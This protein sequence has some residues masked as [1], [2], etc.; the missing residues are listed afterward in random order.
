[1][2]AYSF[3]YSSF[4]SGEIAPELHGRTD[5]APSRS[6]WGKGC[7]VM[8][9]VQGPVVKRGGTRFIGE[10]KV[11]DSAVRLIDFEY[12]TEQTYILEFGDKYI[13]FYKEGGLLMVEEMVFDG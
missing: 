6:G 9:L 1:M 11:S 5:F 8:P 10:V 12:S 13:R 3:Y 7:N 2:A 4:N